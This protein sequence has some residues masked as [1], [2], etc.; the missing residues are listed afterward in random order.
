[1]LCMQTN[2][3]SIIFKRTQKQKCKI[4]KTKYIQIEWTKYEEM[5]SVY[6]G[7]SIYLFLQ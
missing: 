3:D 7:F 1:M 5:G 2:I 6:F 4:K